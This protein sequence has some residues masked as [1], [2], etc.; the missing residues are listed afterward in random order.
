MKTLKERYGDWA[1][2]TGASSGLGEAFARQI[3]AQ[4]MN[5]V[6]L[7]RRGERLDALGNELTERHGIQC[8]RVT[9]DLNA[10]EWLPSLAGQTS[11]LEIGL[12]V[13]NAGF[14]NHG[15]F[16]DNELTSEERLVNVNCRAATTLAHH[17]GQLMRDRKR[18]A[19]IFSASIVGFTSV[20]IWATY[21]ASKSYG[22]LLAEALAVELTTHHIDVMALCPGATRSEFADYQGFWARLFV[23]DADEVVRSALKNLGRKTVHITGLMN[24]MT[25]FAFR[26]MP[27]RLVSIILSAIIRNMVRH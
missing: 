17:Y 27:R 2:I 26:F 24:W 20:P 6:L 19:I 18:G 10:P 15:V 14:A 23:T 9:A 16:L 4:G 8:R 21:A 25:V 5:L 12:L 3:A 13:N 7:A 1:L 22:L 11:D